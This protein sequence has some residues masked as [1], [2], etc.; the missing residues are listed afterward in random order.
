MSAAEIVGAVTHHAISANGIRFHVAEAGSGPAVLLLHGFGQHWRSWRHQ[1]TG[2]ASAHRVIAVDLRGC[3]DSDKP[4]R[5]YDAFTLSDDVA[6]IVRALGERSAALIGT[7]HGGTLAF[8]A[9]VTHPQVF[10]RMVAISAPHPGRMAR[11]RRP[12]RT[13]PYGRL[14]AFCGAPIAP[15]RRL[16]QAHGLLLEKLVRSQAG[17]AWKASADFVTTIAAMRDAIS[18]PGAARGATEPLRWVA[19]SPWRADG[20]RHREALDRPVAVPVLHLVGDGDR[21]TPAVALADAAE[22]CSGSYQLLTIPGVGH[23]P[24]EESPDTVNRLLLEFLAG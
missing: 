18:V 2:L 7:G 24:A 17:P 11:F 19:R 6:G 4:P 10:T 9:A 8:N 12:V 3:G 20:R 5:G 16:A 1:L 22:Q 14:L 15:H 23:Y 13:D 21:F